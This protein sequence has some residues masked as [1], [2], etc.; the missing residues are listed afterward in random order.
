M[1]FN[2]PISK[3]S[4]QIEKKS[5]IVFSQYIHSNKL[6]KKEWFHQVYNILLEK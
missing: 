1:W 3:Y 2:G 5:S 4:I 6:R